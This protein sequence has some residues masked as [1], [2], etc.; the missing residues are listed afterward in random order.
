MRRMKIFQERRASASAETGT[1]AA[2]SVPPTGYEPEV[3]Y[4][5]GK[6]VIEAM[7][8]KY[9]QGNYAGQDAENFMM[10]LQSLKVAAEKYQEQQRWDDAE[11]AWELI[12]SAANDLTIKLDASIQKAH[13]QQQMQPE[14]SSS[15]PAA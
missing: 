12:E 15:G 11:L 14:N 4:R 3:Y 10:A 7:M 5:T 8:R 9:P 6:K 13:C 1:S 2:A